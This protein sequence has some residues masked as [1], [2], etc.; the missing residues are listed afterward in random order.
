MRTVQNFNFQPALE[1]LLI[2]H[3]KFTAEGISYAVS[4]ITSTLTF[5]DAMLKG[6]DRRKSATRTCI[7]GTG[8]IDAKAVCP[9]FNRAFAHAVLFQHLGLRGDQGGEKCKVQ[10]TALTRTIVPEHARSAGRLVLDISLE[11]FLSP[12]AFAVFSFVGLEPGMP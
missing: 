9:R 2:F 12:W 1:T 11:D 6:P 7:S 5:S 4:T 3:L 10:H 8:Q